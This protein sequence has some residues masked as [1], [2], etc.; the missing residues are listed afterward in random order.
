MLELLAELFIL[1]IA[2]QHVGFL[3][4]EMFLWDKPAGMK[5]FRN[6]TEKAAATKVPGPNSLRSLFIQ[7]AFALE[8]VEGEGSQPML[9]RVIPVR[10]SIGRIPSGP[11]IGS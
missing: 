10:D 1:L 7:G 11:P 4:L 6:T 3:V 9:A 8:G 2:L 5:V